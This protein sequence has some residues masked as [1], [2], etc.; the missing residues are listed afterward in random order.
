MYSLHTLVHITFCIA[1]GGGGVGGAGNEAYAVWKRPITLVCGGWDQ[2][3]LGLPP[4]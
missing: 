3:V 1:N 4:G 2:S